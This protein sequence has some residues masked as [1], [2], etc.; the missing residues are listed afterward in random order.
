M[1]EISGRKYAA[2]AIITTYCLVILGSL[3]LSIMKL[4]SL[5]TFLALV[6]GLGGIV[7]YITK[8]YFDDKDRSLENGASKQS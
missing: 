4:M 1:K 6:S 8:A 2:I 5:D 3:L 7:M